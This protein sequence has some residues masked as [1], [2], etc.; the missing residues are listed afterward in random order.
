MIF[1]A[2]SLHLRDLR[3]GILKFDVIEGEY[4]VSTSDWPNICY[5][6]MSSFQIPDS[7]KSLSWLRAD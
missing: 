6:S 3:V 4:E 1:G 7:F 5:K 2:M